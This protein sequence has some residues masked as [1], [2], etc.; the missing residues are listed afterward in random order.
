MSGVHHNK[1][2]DMF[3]IWK[4]DFCKKSHRGS[5]RHKHSFECSECELLARITILRLCGPVSHTLTDILARDH[6]ASIFSLSLRLEVLAFSLDLFFL[7][8]KLQYVLHSSL[9]DKTPAETNM[10]FVGLSLFAK[11]QVLDL[12]MCVPTA[13]HCEHIR[14]TQIGIIKSLHFRNKSK[15]LVRIFLILWC[16]IFNFH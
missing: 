15:Q 2:V 12:Q 8:D 3:I 13:I 4:N 11:P 7:L 14:H 1:S 5:C 9:I 10:C 16:V 6:I